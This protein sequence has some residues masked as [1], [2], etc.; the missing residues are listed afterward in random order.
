MAK[1]L[2]VIL[3]AVFIAATTLAAP[4]RR[5]VKPPPMD[6][7]TPAGWLA[8]HAAFFTASESNGDVSDLAPIGPLIGDATLVGLGDGTHGTHEYFVAKRR[9]IEYLVRNKDFDEVDFEGEYPVFAQIDAYINGAPGD[10]KQLVF[11]PTDAYYFFWEVQE[12][13]DVIECMRDYNLHRPAGVRAI[14]VGGAD[15]YGAVAMGSAVASYLD[16]VDPGAAPKARTN[17]TCVTSTSYFA[18]PNCVAAVKE[19]R[20][21]IAA[22]QADYVAASSQREFDE[23][24]HQAD[25]IAGYTLQERDRLMAANAIWLR[26]HHSAT[27]KS[28]F[29]AHQEHV[30]R[31]STLTKPAGAFITE[32]IGAS[33][34]AFG[35]A[36]FDGTFLASAAPNASTPPKIVAFLP[37]TN[38]GYELS[39]YSAGALRM[40][41]PLRAAP[42]KWLSDSHHLRWGDRASANNTVEMLPAKFDAVVYIEFTTP[43]HWVRGE[44]QP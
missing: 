9:I 33:Y 29:W 17:Y 36:T 26:D 8:A 6:V 28:I 18:M 38:D 21:A 7:A 44:G 1:K 19:T 13:V 14:R 15:I 42:P 30:G 20:D 5:A 39:L 2:A 11:S 24:S 3:A 37:L 16:R 41:I 4:R 25:L 27:H 40:M 43:N 32:Q 12:L 35:N 22:H 31:T 34:F 23:I 10:A